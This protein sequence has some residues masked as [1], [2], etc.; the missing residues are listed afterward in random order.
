MLYI[1]NHE[2]YKSYLETTNYKHILNLFTP[3]FKMKVLGPLIIEGEAKGNIVGINLKS[4]DYENEN[5]IEKVINYI[6]KLK[7]E[8]T[9]EIYIEEL[10]EDNLGIK[11]VIEKETGLSFPSELDL[12]LYNMRLILDKILK[13]NS[14]LVEKEVLIICKDRKLVCEIITMIYKDFPFISIVDEIQDQE[15]ICEEILS[16]TGL[17]ISRVNDLNRMIQNYGIIIN[18]E[19]SISIS[20]ES[21]KKSS[22]VFDF[23]KKGNFRTARGYILIEDIS[24]SDR[25]FKKPS[26]LP[27]EIPSSLYRS[28][29]GK[30]EIGFCRIYSRGKLYTFDEIISPKDSLRGNI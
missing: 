18:V 26:L 9:K 14:L 1:V 28:L 12:K 17:S 10:G 13:I 11:G 30:E 20:P 5:H 6:N 2:K 25:D 3:M 23:S 8:K 24:I 16:D 15:D 27:S 4:I 22:I 7:D 21:I 19:K 29:T